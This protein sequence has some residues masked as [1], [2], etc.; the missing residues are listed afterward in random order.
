MAES[1]LHLKEDERIAYLE[2][3]HIDPKREKVFDELTEL[4]CKL[5]DVPK[6]LISIVH[7][8]EVWF[9]SQKDLS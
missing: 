1:Q 6:S 3:F 2:S 7:R 8:E 4:A 9:K 5:T